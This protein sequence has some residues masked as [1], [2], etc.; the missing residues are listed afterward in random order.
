MLLRTL[1][2]VH[3]V[4]N[5]ADNF[6]IATTMNRR[7]LAAAMLAG[8]SAFAAAPMPASQGCA[9]PV[10][11][12][13]ERDFR[14]YIAAFNRNDFAGFSR[15]YATDVKFEG[16]AGTFNS[17][18]QVVAFYRE[19]KA[20]MRETITIQDLI[21]G[22]NE[23]VANIVTELHALRDWPEFATGPVSKGQT[24]TWHNMDSSPHQVTIT[25]AKS[26]R[27]SIALKGQTTRL[28]L[29][30]LA[31]FGRGLVV[32]ATPVRPVAA[33]TP[34]LRSSDEVLSSQ[35]RMLDGRAGPLPARATP[36]ADGVRCR[37][38]G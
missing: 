24:I 32:S 2:R 4:H 8:G 34:N 25:G 22:D 38:R 10:S 30:E 23:I 16:R 13:G 5:R 29:A 3:N 28:T 36:P 31:V 14:N 35:R 33:P 20:R 26:Q 17:R 1:L 9:N 19:V 21:V 27:S 6:M 11:G 18:D 37:S 15:Y 7:S 12:L